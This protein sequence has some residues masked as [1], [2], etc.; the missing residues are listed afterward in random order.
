MSVIRAEKLNHWYGNVVALNDVSLEIGPGITGIL[1]PNGAGKTS[2]MRAVVGLLRP[3]MGTVRVLD[4]DP[5]NNPRLNLRIGYCPEHDGFY[6][7]LTGRQFVRTLLALRGFGAK[8]AG[9]AA[10]A[11][12]RVRLTDAADRRVGTYSRGMRQRLKLAQAVAHESKLLVLDE[13]LT[14]TDPLVRAE[15]IELIRSFAVEGRHVI[16]SSHVL[17]EIEALTSNIVVIHR[18]RLVAFGDRREIR[19]LIDNHPHSVSIRA[20]KARELAAALAAEPSVTSIDF[21]D[22]GLLVRTR[23]PDAFYGRLP[24]LALG[25]GCDVR[26]IT[27]PDDNLE[28]VFRYLTES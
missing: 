28:A 13:P 25:A 15:L 1:G 6:E 20:T 2:L 11:I 23:Q 7:W 22:G 3:T 24:G 8:S 14:G 16:V 17:H 5:W 9:L 26:E 18:G 27:S 4:E 21:R 10:A 19:S 12:E